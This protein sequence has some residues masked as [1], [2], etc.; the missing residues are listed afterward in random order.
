MCVLSFLFN[1]NL[2]LVS[3]NISSVH[4]ILQ[5]ISVL[6]KSILTSALLG[7]D[8]HSVCFVIR[9]SSSHPYVVQILVFSLFFLSQLFSLL[10]RDLRFL[11]TSDLVIMAS[12][13]Y[14][15]SMFCYIYEITKV[16]YEIIIW[17]EKLVEK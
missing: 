15:I 4:L 13:Y 7:S 8:L 11:P 5:I 3:H 6:I 17:E 12:I 1:G 16:W 2:G 9:F 10:T 14:Q